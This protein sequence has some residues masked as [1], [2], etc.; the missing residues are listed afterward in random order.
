MVWTDTDAYIASSEPLE[1]VPWV[2]PVD[3]SLC[4][5]FLIFSP[6]SSIDLYLFY[7]F[8]DF[9]SCVFR[10]WQLT[11]QLANTPRPIRAH[12]LLICEQVLEEYRL[13]NKTGGG[14]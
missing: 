4:L 7:L 9:T 3:R 5:P 12:S 11:G 8:S 2:G 1:T 10:V 13:L 14:L 6:L